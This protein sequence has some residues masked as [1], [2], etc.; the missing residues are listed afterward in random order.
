MHGAK[1]RNTGGGSPFQ[2]RGGDPWVSEVS[3]RDPR[4][5]SKS[6]EA[7]KPFWS[8]TSNALEESTTHDQP[9]SA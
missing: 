1:G 6:A 3:P 7:G 4:G 2:A 9:A 5:R 8:R